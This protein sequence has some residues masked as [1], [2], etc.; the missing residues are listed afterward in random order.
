M[1]KNNKK[2]RVFGYK[3]IFDNIKVGKKD[4]GMRK[5]VHSSYLSIKKNNQIM[6]GV[7]YG[8]DLNYQ[9]YMAFLD[10]VREEEELI[11]KNNLKEKNNKEYLHALNRKKMLTQKISFTDFE[12]KFK[13]N[14]Y[15]LQYMDYYDIQKINRLE[16][17][18]FLREENNKTTPIKQDKDNEY[19]YSEEE[20]TDIKNKN[21][22]KN[23]II[24]Y[25]KTD[26]NFETKKNKYEHFIDNCNNNINHK[27]IKRK[28]SKHK[29][30]KHFKK[31]HLSGV[32]FNLIN[33]INSEA[34][35]VK[36]KITKIKYFNQL[37]KEKE[38]INR[39][40][41]KDSYNNEK[42][43]ININ[44]ILDQYT[45][46]HSVESKNINKLNKL[47]MD[48][49]KKMVEENLPRRNKLSKTLY[50]NK[51]ICHLYIPNSAKYKH[52]SYCKE[53]LFNK[54]Y[55]LNNNNKKKSIIYLKNNNRKK[56][57][58]YNDINNISKI[59]YLLK[60]QKNNLFTNSNAYFLVPNDNLLTK[61][62]NIITNLKQIK[63]ILKQDK[64]YT[65]RTINRAN[66]KFQDKER[67]RQDQKLMENVMRDDRKYFNKMKEFQKKRKNRKFNENNN[68]FCTL[69]Q[70]NDFYEKDKKIHSEMSNQFSRSLN[71]LCKDEKRENR[72]YKKVLKSNYHLKLEEGECDNNIKKTKDIIDKN[73]DYLNC[74]REKIKRKCDEINDIITE[75]CYKN[76][77]G[78]F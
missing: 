10:K 51:P 16:I 64:N 13:I 40:L 24:K 48:L 70:I 56:S 2:E 52:I 78:I 54:E 35:K 12:N 38:K 22:N 34:L 23:N 67:I 39:K 60:N 6:K 50:Q 76:K 73:Q 59:S 43:N 4:M 55:K 62:N 25:N 45:I 75:S 69:K 72:V 47:K 53:C 32:D 3:K 33:K 27:I 5:R 61:T 66:K 77:N 8:N 9:R 65:S 74:L 29:S 14:P 11:K 46:Y 26:N 41:N 57:F 58:D 1:N 36:K 30:H 7:S 17:E 37:R 15:F 42:N 49:D 20:K 18:R 28:S 71:I 31:L 21:K 44:E 19:Y 68:V 63:N